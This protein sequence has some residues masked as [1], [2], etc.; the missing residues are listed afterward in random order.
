MT[1]KPIL[2]RPV[3]YQPPDGPEIKGEFWLHDDGMLTVSCKYGTKTGEP[4]ETPPVNFAR[5]LM[6]ELYGT[7]LGLPGFTRTRNE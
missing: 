5:M 1:E 4:R 7:A 2:R 3:R 6:H